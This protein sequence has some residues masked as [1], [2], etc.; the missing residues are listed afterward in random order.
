MS[1]VTLNGNPFRSNFNSGN[2]PSSSPVATTTSSCLPP[3]YDIITDLANPFRDLLELQ[4]PAMIADADSIPVYPPS[5]SP[6][7]GDD[8]HAPTPA[9]ASLNIPD[10]DEVLAK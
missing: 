4:Q 2:N 8:H 10:P 7:S 1:P 6:L 5:T 3:H 9:Y